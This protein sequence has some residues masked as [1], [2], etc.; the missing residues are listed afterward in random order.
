VDV[1]PQVF[2]AGFRSRFF[3]VSEQ[4]KVSLA[5]EDTS[6]EA[7]IGSREGVRE[8]GLRD[9]KRGKSAEG[10]DESLSPGPV[11]LDAQPGSALAADDAGGG[12]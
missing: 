4:G 2:T 9:G 8:L 7:R 10:H 5:W 6:V 11:V 1:A 12:V 3:R